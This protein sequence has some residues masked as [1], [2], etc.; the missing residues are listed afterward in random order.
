MAGNQIKRILECV[1]NFSEGRDVYVIEKIRNSIE[2]VEGVKLLLVDVGHSAN[3]SVMTF[4]GEPEKVI[5]AA[6]AAA[7]CAAEN[8]N[9]AVHKGVHP[10]IGAIDVI[11][12]VPVSGI[13]MEETIELSLQLSKEIGD[14]LTIPVYCYEKSALKPEREKLQNIRRGEYEGLAGKMSDNR[15]KPDFGP[16]IFNS[17]TGATVVGARN[18]LIAFNVNLNTQ[19]VDTASKIASEIRE[20]GRFV[21][22]KEGTFKQIPGLLSGVKAIGWFIKEIN[23]SQVSMNITDMNK[24]PLHIAFETVKTAAM[25]NNVEVTGSELIGLLPLK[26][27]VDAGCYFSGISSG[28]ENQLIKIAVENLGLDEINPF[29]PG[30]R[31]IEYAIAKLK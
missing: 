31:I 7:K 30:E 1:P 14:K 10:R 21:P 17:R 2:S 28:D 26:A 9:M 24:T 27:I 23:R 11:P 25:K 16:E 22:D 18:I 15:W 19:S 8:I 20:S 29:R 12:L 3:R 13:T 4:A 6:F 5:E